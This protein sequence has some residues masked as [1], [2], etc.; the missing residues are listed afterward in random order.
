MYLL[1]K[2]DTAFIAKAL[3]DI[4]RA[5]GMMQIARETRLPLARLYKHSL[6][7]ETQPLLRF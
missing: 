6:V 7:I 1:L 3:R 5:K 4:A 2:H